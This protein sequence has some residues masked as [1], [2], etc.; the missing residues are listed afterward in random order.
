MGVAPEA[1][2]KD[3]CLVV[4]SR[5]FYTAILEILLFVEVAP[6]HLGKN[7]YLIKGSRSIQ[8]T[9]PVANLLLFSCRHASLNQIYFISI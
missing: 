7:L 2:A 5:N 3:L 9:P 1:T 6:E 4:G 8:I